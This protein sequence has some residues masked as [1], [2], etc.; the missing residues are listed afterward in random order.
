V[1]ITARVASGDLVGFSRDVPRIDPPLKCTRET[2]SIVS[3]LQRAWI[4]AHQTLEAVANTD[5]VEPLVERL[6]RRGGNDCVDTGS[7]P[8]TDEDG[9]AL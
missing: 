1:S 4:A 6:D 7:R 3:G 2:S 5:D 8:A 9:E